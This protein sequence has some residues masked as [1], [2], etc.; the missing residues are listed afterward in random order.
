M[1][2]LERVKSIINGCWDIGENQNE[3]ASIEKMILIAYYI[4]RESAT[5][6]V[7]DKYSELIKEQRNRAE[8]CRYHKMAN[9]I[10]RDKNYIFFCDY[11]QDT[12]TTFGN[13]RSDI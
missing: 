5:K 4:G 11:S 13:D 7:S 1:T 12:T 3:P 6:E 8:N 10:I 2:I 9:E